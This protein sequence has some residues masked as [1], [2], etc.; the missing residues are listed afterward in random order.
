QWA[1]PL[2]A[3]SGSF[4]AA[5]IAVQGSNIYVTGGTAGIANAVAKLDA[6]SGTVAWTVSL[7]VSSSTT[8]SFMGVAVGQSTGNVYVT[9]STASSQAFVARLDATGA[10]Q[11]IKT[12][13]GGSAGGVRVAVYDAPNNGPESVY[14]TGSYTGTTTFGATP[15]TSLPGSS[16]VWE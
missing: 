16:F 5:D 6:T 1:T 3:L 11:W 14:L 9:G 15:L 8:S 13:S 4:W 12:T 2:P 7:P 10:I